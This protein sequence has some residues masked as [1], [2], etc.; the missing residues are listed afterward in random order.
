MKY[1]TFNSSCSYAGVAN[2]LEER[3]VDVEDRELV[4]LGDIPY[5]FCREGDAFL[6]GP[7]LQS[8][9]WFDH[10]LRP[11]GYALAEREAERE[12][13]PDILH[14]CGCR[15]MLG[16]T[17]GGRKHAYVFEAHRDGKFHFINNKHRAS[18]GPERT[19]LGE[20]ELLAA[21]EQRVMVASLAPC[22]R[23][24][25][26]AGKCRDMAASLPALEE[27]RACVD[28]YASASVAV[29]TLRGDMDRVFRA[30][31][32]GLPAVLE[33]AGEGDL[34]ARFAAL[35]A[36]FMAAVRQ[37]GEVTLW[38]FVP[39]GAFMNALDVYAEVI[40]R[41]MEQMGA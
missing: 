6:A 24:E 32:L 35:M 8:K 9:H 16:L 15:C 41:R 1:M 10:C 11:Q 40:R 21:L 22:A 26:R 4:C 27:Y 38:D 18:D 19:V 33:I 20:E 37:E 31:L 29:Q 36:P 2:L 30:A 34:A 23:E 3:G 13:V 25:D 5:F 7:E 17:A 12:E 39:R 14:A 28:V